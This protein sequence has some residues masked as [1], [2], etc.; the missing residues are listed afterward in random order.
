MN[1]TNAARTEYGDSNHVSLQEYFVVRVKRF[2]SGGSRVF[3]RELCDGGVVGAFCHLVER[4]FPVHL[5][6]EFHAVVGK[7]AACLFQG[8]DKGGK[9]VFFGTPREILQKPATDFVAKFVDGIVWRGGEAVRPV[10]GEGL[11]SAPLADLSMSA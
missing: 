4:K 1:A 2:G 11:T 9:V 3:C 7:R 5:R 8:I 6:D 10:L